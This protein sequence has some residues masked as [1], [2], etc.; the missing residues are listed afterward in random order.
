MSP[1]PNEDQQRHSNP[2]AV[3]ETYRVAGEEILLPYLQRISGRSRTATKQLIAS[4]CVSVDHGC[5]T[6]ATTLMRSGTLVTV[7]A[8]PMPKEYK[9]PKIRI[10]WQDENYLLVEKQAGIYTVNT[11]HRNREDTII[12]QVGKYLKESDPGAKLFMINRLDSESSGFV[13]FAKSIKAKE[14]LI[15]NWKKCV[16]EQKFT[17]VITGTLPEKEFVIECFSN[18]PTGIKE[19]KSFRPRRTEAAIRCLKSDK[20]NNV[21]VVEVDIKDRI[22]SLRKLMRDNGYHILGEGQQTMRIVPKGQIALYQTT[23][24]LRIPF[25]GQGRSLS[26]TRKFPT[27][28]F[29]YLRHAMPVA[30]QN[31]SRTDK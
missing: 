4:G 9:H 25:G 12:W 5:T 21:H 20:T 29:S 10:V 7:H 6:V 8:H 1:Y 23:L 31:T 30:Q 24:S 14:E 28:F 3:K 18:P 22:F 11:T 17:L 26:F 27:H 19:K 16:T 13:L 2:S 15:Q